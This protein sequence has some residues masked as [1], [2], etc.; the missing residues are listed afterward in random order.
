MTTYPHEKHDYPLRT[1][2]QISVG[3]QYTHSPGNVI[4]GAPTA[5][6][7]RRGAIEGKPRAGGRPAPRRSLLVQASGSGP[8]THAA[9]LGSH[10]YNSIFPCHVQGFLPELDRW[11]RENEKKK[12]GGRERRGGL[13]LSLG[14]PAGC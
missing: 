5:A 12:K 10:P 4:G 13:D 1:E 7:T 11:N 6:V 2:L 8:R 3:Y 14:L 9:V